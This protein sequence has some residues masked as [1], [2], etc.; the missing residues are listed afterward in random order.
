MRRHGRRHVRQ[1]QVD[2]D[3]ALASAAPFGSV[4]RMIL[5]PRAA[6]S[7]MFD[8]VFS[9]TP[10]AG[11]LVERRDH[12]HRHGLVDQRD[13][14]VLELAR[15]IAFGVDVGDFLELQRAFERDRIGGA[16]AEIEHV[17]GFGE[18]ARQ[19]LDLRLQRERLGHDGAA[20]RSARGPDCARR[21]P[22]GCRG[23]GPPRWRGRAAPQAG[24]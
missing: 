14:A 24:R 17:A 10:S 23:C 7:C 11:A 6:T 8:T 2:S 13:R 5:P 1:H 15:R 21:P 4:T 9:N 3:S 20:P 19:R 12:D 22:T 16:A 18:I